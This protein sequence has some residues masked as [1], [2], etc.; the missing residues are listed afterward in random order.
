MM[1]PEPYSS[2]TLKNS[3]L[4]YNG[5]DFPCN[6]RK[7]AFVASTKESVHNFGVVNT[8]I[9]K[10][11]VTHSGG[12]CQLSFTE[13]LPT[14]KESTWEVIKSYEYEP[15]WTGTSTLGA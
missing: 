7:D 2:K 9:F 5:S 4:A 8:V 11:R 12:S 3:P 13:D 1:S 6:S 15:V 14:S 10:G